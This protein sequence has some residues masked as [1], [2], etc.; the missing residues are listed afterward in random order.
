MNSSP[1]LEVR[2]LRVE[3]ASG[4]EIVDNVSFS[5]DRG[6]VLALVGESGCGKTCVAMSL[7]GHARPGTQIAGGEVVLEG[8]DILALAPSDLRGI[9]GAKVSYVPQDPSSSLSPR[10]KIGDQL[11]EAMISHGVSRAEARHRLPQLMT[12]VKLPLDEKLLTRYPFELSG[13]QQQRVLIAMALALTP[14]VVVLDEPTTGLDVT[15]QSHILEVLGEL[16]SSQNVAFVYVTHDLAVVEEIADQVCV[17]YAGRLVESGP[18]API[19]AEPAHPYTETLLASVPRISVRH[20]LVGA[21]G[22]A[23]PPGERPPGCF[24]QP[25]CPVAVESCL[26]EFPP[27]EPSSTG[28]TVRCFRADTLRL[29]LKPLGEVEKHGHGAPLLA[30]EGLTASYGDNVAASEVGF[31]IQPGECIGLVGESGSGKTTTG[32]CIAG[33]HRLDSGTVTFEGEELPALASDRTAVQLRR[34]QVIFQNPDRSLNPSHTVRRLI[35]R[36]LDVL[37]AGDG[38]AGEK[39]IVELLDRV[40]LSPQMLERYPVQLS[41][42]EKQ[43]VAIARAL[44]GAPELLICDE[45]T[46]ALDVSIQAAIVSLLEDLRQEGLAILFITHNLGVVNVIADRTL[47]MQNGRVVEEGL[48]Q[49]IIANPQ[50]AYTRELIAA[51]PDL[52]ERPTPQPAGGGRSGESA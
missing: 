16:G 13:G 39:R 47:V 31:E 11:L 20:E 24:F 6:E 5:V 4:L 2:D 49:P 19:L 14:S 32:R 26:R 46:S 37:G 43:R 42:G 38:D 1:V 12:D 9:R 27:P 17:M 33:L 29:E 50:N 48:T 8:K 22:I 23:P 18:R 52:S 35:T 3:T 21:T 7:L 10:M 30:V 34:L 44:A 51:A 45:I 15:T 25:R 41:G 40:R 36:Q 28:G